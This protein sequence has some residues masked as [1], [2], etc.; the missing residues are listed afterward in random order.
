M[1][2]RALGTQ[3]GVSKA[4]NMMGLAFRRQCTGERSP[5]VMGL[6]TLPERAEGQ[7]QTPTHTPSVNQEAEP[8]EPQG[9]P[10][11]GCAERSTVSG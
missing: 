2:R 3:T 5:G 9:E 6:G 10:E 8:G 4:E 7:G 1:G 11:R